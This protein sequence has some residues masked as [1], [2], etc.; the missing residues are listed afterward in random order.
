[1]IAYQRIDYW[2]DAPSDSDHAYTPTM[3]LV[4]ETNKNMNLGVAEAIANP[5]VE[6]DFDALF[7]KMDAALPALKDKYAGLHQQMTILVKQIKRIDP[8]WTATPKTPRL[9][10]A[11]REVLKG[12]KVGM[13]VKEIVENLPNEFDGIELSEVENTID[14]S[15][16]RE[17]PLFV[18]DG[19]GLISLAKKG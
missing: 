16:S 14:T 7:S 1:M 3:A 17:K 10:Y 5:E 4:K 19:N 13:L 11:V 2:A 9:D 18:K 12:S 8:T 6:V 15:L